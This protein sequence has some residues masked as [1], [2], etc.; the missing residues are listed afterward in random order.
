[1]KASA[2]VA[3]NQITTDAAFTG[4]IKCTEFM[5]SGLTGRWNGP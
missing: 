1:L 3:P 4:G 2:C 5:P